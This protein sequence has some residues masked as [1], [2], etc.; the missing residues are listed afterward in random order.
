MK[1]E[2][3]MALIPLLITILFLIA[4]AGATIFM[5]GDGFLYNKDI[6]RTVQNETNTIERNNSIDINTIDNNN[7]KNE[8]KVTNRIS[9]EEA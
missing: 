3:G 4:I 1:S 6:K 9:S 5:I 8:N 2:K 7:V